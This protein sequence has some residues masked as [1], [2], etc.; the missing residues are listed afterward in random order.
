MQKSTEKTKRR[1]AAPWF[2]LFASEFQVETAGM[3]AAEKGIY[4]ALLCAMHERG[5]PIAEDYSRLARL[6]G[7]TPAALKSALDTL[8]KAGLIYHWEPEYLWSSISETE[9][10][11]REK[12]S[13]LQRE[14]SSK[15]WQKGKQNQRSNNAGGYRDKSIRYKSIEVQSLSETEPHIPTSSNIDSRTEA[16]RA[17]AQP[18]SVK[19]DD[20]LSIPGIGDCWV[21][22]IVSIKPYQFLVEAR[23]DE[24]LSHA[25]RVD[26]QFQHHEISMHEAE[27]L[28]DLSGEIHDQPA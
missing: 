8:M 5:E 25:F 1:K 19:V 15:R 23:D 12:Y 17:N 16:A 28:P 13:E 4:I 9:F 11:N 6:S 21:T 24:G 3:K 27:A 2:R 10:Q 14:K 20:E 18:R 22:K 26:R 7:T